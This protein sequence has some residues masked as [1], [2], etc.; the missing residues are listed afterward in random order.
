[1]K[2][3]DIHGEEE[4]NEDIESGFDASGTLKLSRPVPVATSSTSN[5]IS[6]SALDALSPPRPAAAAAVELS[7]DVPNMCAICLDSYQP[8]QIVAW[9]SGCTHAFH[10]DCISHYLAKK[11]I[12]GETPC[13]SCRQKF[14]DLPED[15][16]SSSIADNNATVSESTD[17]PRSESTDAPRS[18]SESTDAPRSVSESTDAPP[19]VSESTDAPHHV[20]RCE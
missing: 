10:Q 13:P 11:M 3:E 12:G 17:A 1:V 16:L 15:P 20:Q 18:E 8:D 7:A 6:D 2:A 9:S 19:S 5:S 4:G 14:C